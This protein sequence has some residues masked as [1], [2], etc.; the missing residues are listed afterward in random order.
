MKM[1]LTSQ[2]ALR[3]FLMHHQRQKKSLSLL[4]RSLPT[5]KDVRTVRR[6]NVAAERTI[7]EMDRAEILTQSRAEVHQDLRVQLLQMR[8]WQISRRLRARARNSL[9]RIRIK[10]AISSNMKSAVKEETASLASLTRETLRN[11]LNTERRRLQRL[12]SLKS[13]SKSYFQRVQWL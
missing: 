12:L 4:A 10:I 6:M 7:R 5:K 9:T 13:K 3:R 8:L 11:R 2:C 1:L